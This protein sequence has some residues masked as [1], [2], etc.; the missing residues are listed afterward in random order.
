MV[1]YMIDINKLILH[2]FNL[3]PSHIS[4]ISENSSINKVYVVSF[5]TRKLI[6]RLRYDDKY[7]HNEFM[8]EKWFSQQCSI[9]DV[10]V[11]KIFK[12]G[13][14]DNMDYL[15]E[16][17]IDGIPGNIYKDRSLVFK[18]LGEYSR[19]IKNISVHGY[20]LNLLNEQNNTFSDEL[21]KSPQEQILKNLNAINPDDNLI[22]L[23]IYCVNDIKNIR[24][25]FYSLLNADM[26]CYLNHGDI[27]LANSIV[28]PKG[29]IFLIDFGSVNSNI[30]LNELANVKVSSYKDMIDFMNGFGEDLRNFNTNINS[31]KLLSAFDKLRWSLDF[32]NQ[33]YIDWYIKNAKDIFKTFK[34]E[35]H[36]F[37]R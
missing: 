9:V 16:E 6:F 29:K 15:I 18:K 14:I 8:K 5:S 34:F 32:K 24:N 25:I 11:P 21:Y 2:E 17:Y 20:G 3:V 35:N 31:Y 13:N 10:P 30:L 36:T 1:I 37:E 33:E 22:K 23:N 27:S 4:L 19:K 26:S 7:A 12:I 28:T